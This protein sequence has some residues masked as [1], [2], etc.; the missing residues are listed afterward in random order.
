MDFCNMEMDVTARSSLWNL[1]NFD[2]NPA[3]QP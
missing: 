3:C 2:V 1:E